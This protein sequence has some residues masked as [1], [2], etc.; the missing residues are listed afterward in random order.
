MGEKEKVFVE[1][2]IL[3]S[4]EEYEFLAKY[5]LSKIQED[6]DELVNYAINSILEEQMKE[7]KEND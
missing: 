6:K 1:V 2:D 4:D 5:G 7:L 3:I